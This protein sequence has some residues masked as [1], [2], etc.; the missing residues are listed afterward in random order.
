MEIGDGRGEGTHGTRRKDVL[1]EE[2]ALR[3]NGEEVDELVEVAAH[4]VE[5]LLGH[6]VVLARAHLR[7]EARVEEGAAGDLGRDGNAQGHPGQL[8]G[9]AQQVEVAGAEDEEDDR[10]VG[11]GGGARV[12]PAEE[13]REE[14]VVVGE[15][16]AR[17][18][19]GRWSLAGTGEVGELVR[20]LQGL[21]SDVFGDGS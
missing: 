7:R 10:D 8:E 1:G 13:A 18:G 6:D 4:L 14:G 3:L 21:V 16:L 15:L 19:L 5:G 2:Q 11:D 20:G 17:G 9:I 12:L